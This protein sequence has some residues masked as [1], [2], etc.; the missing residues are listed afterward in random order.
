[1]QILKVEDPRDP[2]RKASRYELCQLAKMHGIK[3]ISYGCDMQLP[4]MIEMLHERGIHTITIPERPLG[5]QKNTIY[6]ADDIIAKVP[7]KVPAPAE[8]IAEKSVSDM[9]MTEMRKECKRRGIP[10]V[11]TDNLKTLREKLGG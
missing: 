9:N 8:P 7:D 3:E 10:M 5:V 11:R 4:Q 1:M 6:N 2:L